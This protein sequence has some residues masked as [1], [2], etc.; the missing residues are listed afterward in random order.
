MFNNKDPRGQGA[1]ETLPATWWLSVSVKILPTQT[2]KETFIWGEP[3]NVFLTKYCFIFLSFIPHKCLYRLEHVIGRQP[4]VCNLFM[5]YTIW[6]SRVSPVSPGFITDHPD[7][8]PA[9]PTPLEF[10]LELSDSKNMKTE[11]MAGY[12]YVNISDG[13]H[14]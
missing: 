10:Y 2:I 12:G 3:R 6:A 13:S 11:L 5:I 7:A 14:M 1:G 9:P 8:P 4:F